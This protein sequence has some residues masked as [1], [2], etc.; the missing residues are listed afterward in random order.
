[1]RKASGNYQVAP[2]DSLLP[3][4]LLVDARYS[5]TRWSGC[6]A[7]V[8]VLEEK[9]RLATSGDEGHIQSME[10]QIQA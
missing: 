2:V 4:Q 1:M 7:E 6:Q 10:H 3:L 5:L 8:R 9:L